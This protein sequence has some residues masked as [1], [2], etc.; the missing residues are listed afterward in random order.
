MNDFLVS[1]LNF[2]DFEP[3]FGLTDE[4]LLSRGMRRMV[5]DS[6]PGYPCRVSL[7]DAQVGEEVILLTYTH[8][9]TDSPYQSSG[10]I[11]VR[12]IA[13]TARPEVNEIPLMLNHRLLS[14]RAYDAEGMMQ[15]ARVVEGK[16]LKDEINDIFS[17]EVISYIHVHN[18]KPGCFNCGVKRVNRLH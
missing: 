10:P 13:K 3:L 2:E 8:H 6:F 14:L 7:E 4:Q 17:N 15:E 16:N 11:F 12:K 9:K 5:V 1:A 18:A